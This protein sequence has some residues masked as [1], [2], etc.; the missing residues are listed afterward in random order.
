MNTDQ[1]STPQF[2]FNELIDYKS[3]FYENGVLKKQEWFKNHKLHRKGGPAKIEY[4]RNGKAWS[5]AWHKDGQLHRNSGPAV[6][7]Y[8]DNGSVKSEFWYLNNE[9]HRKNA[10]AY[11]C[12]CEETGRITEESWFRRGKEHR[13]D[14]PAEIDYDGDGFIDV[15]SYYING[16]WIPESK[17]EATVV[18]IF[19]KEISSTKKSTDKPKYSGPSL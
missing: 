1:N 9:L 4:N 6:I 5:E 11:I 10:P 17:F 13:L 15:C 16:E 7:T 3:T 8:H 19:L 2:K 12:R 18:K 14:G